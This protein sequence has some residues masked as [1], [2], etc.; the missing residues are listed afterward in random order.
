MM[1]ELES[2]LIEFNKD[3]IIKDKKYLSNY[4]INNANW[5]LIIIITYDENIFSINNYI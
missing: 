3:E 2:Y 5:R 4:T 1:K